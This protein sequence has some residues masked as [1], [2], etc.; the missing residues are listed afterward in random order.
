MFEKLTRAA[1]ERIARI[2]SL[3]ASQ[4]D[5]VV[6]TYAEFVFDA[7]AIA[8]D[9][10]KNEARY[11][12]DYPSVVCLCPGVD[13]DAVMNGCLG[14]AVTTDWDV[15]IRLCEK[16]EPIVLVAT[17]CFAELNGLAEVGWLIAPLAS[18]QSDKD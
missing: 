12:T 18:D 10:L 7:A 4:V 14:F 9:N 8:A 13:W 17:K 16:G 6:Q 1:I 2:A 15:A 11:F 5:A 3:N